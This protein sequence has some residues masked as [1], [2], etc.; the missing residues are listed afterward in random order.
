MRG[1]NLEGGM[2]NL[3]VAV[4]SATVFFS[5]SVQAQGLTL[6]D[7]ISLAVKNNLTV[8]LARAQTESAR[9]AVLLGASGLLPDI[10]GSAYQARVF[11]VNLAAQGLSFPG[12]P[13]TLGPFDTFDARIS[14]VQSIFDL[15]AVRRYQASKQA[16]RLAQ[17]AEDLA[18]EQ[19]AAAAALAY[20]EA[21]RSRQLVDTAAS[22]VNLAETLLRLTEDQHHSGVAAG[23][24]V[25]RAQTRAKEAH[26]REVQARVAQRNADVRLA[27]VTG[28]PLD[29]PPA[30]APTLT[31]QKP[32]LEEPGAAVSEALTRRLE[33]KVA[34]AAAEAD[35]YSLKA[36]Q[37]EYLP[38]LAVKG[39]Y[40]AS[41]NTPRLKDVP[42]SSVGAAIRMPLFNSGRTQGKVD[43][44]RAVR[45][46]SDARL[47]DMRAQVEA[48]ARLALDTLSAAVEQVET[49]DETE[50]LA[51]KELELARDRYASGVGDNIGLVNAQDAL[52]R[53]KDE[54]VASL[55][56]FH[57]ARVNLALALGRM[58]TYKF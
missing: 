34:E 19:V 12:F 43:Q 41:G 20:I 32:Q 40:G 3:A 13:M 4:F 9:G 52:A 58:G 21:Q 49:S 1:R 2:W 54:Q 33:L 35:R 10:T 11:R 25:A 55:S 53:A 28:L 57:V 16:R 50:K 44:A 48:D 18:R 15:G 23:I 5:A 7:A 51:E 37:D 36:A 30:L 31:F 45:E 46:A 39:D 22:D 8:K 38:V 6:E 27:R 42:T 26:L 47:D 24:D 56:A 29:Q 14:L 17:A